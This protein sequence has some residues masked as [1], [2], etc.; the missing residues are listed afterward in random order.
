MIR[1]FKGKLPNFLRLCFTQDTMDKGYYFAENGDALIGF[2]HLI[3][4]NGF[5]VGQ[6]KFRFLGYSNS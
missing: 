3:M 1:E 2:I 5:N 6:L 4:T